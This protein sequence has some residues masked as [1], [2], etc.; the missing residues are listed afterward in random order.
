M[1]VIAMQMLIITLGCR[2]S[3]QYLNFFFFT[4]I[5]ENVAF[6]NVCLYMLAVK[7]NDLKIQ[8]WQASA[9]IS[10]HLNTAEAP[11]V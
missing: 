11:C 5:E 10:T 7:G 3:F 2:V 4:M 9:S 6:Q 8:K 1:F